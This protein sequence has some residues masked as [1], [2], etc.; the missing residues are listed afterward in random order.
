VR[1]RNTLLAFLVLAG[2]GAWIY[3][4]EYRGEEARKKAEEGEKKVFVFEQDKVEALELVKPDGT[5]SLKKEG[6]EWRLAAPLSARADGDEVSGLLSTLSWLQVT[7]KVATGASDLDA[8]KL[9]EPALRIVLSPGEGK[10]PVS[11]SVGDKAPIGFAYYARRDDSA[12]V[13]AVSSS[14]DRLLEA[15]AEKLRYKKV[16]G[17]DSWKV[18]RFAVARAGAMVAFAKTGEEWKMESPIAFPAERSKVSNLLYDLTA[19]T[20]EGFEPDGTAPGAVGLDPPEATL[21][22][23]EKEGRSVTVEFSAKDPN[24]IARARRTDMP[25]IFLVKGDV[26][27]K[28]ALKIEEFRDARVAPVDRW[29]ISEIRAVTAEGEKKVVKDT[30]ANWRWGSE[31]GPTLDR[32]KVDDLLDALDA[33]KGT[34]FREGPAA[35]AGPGE[36]R[37]TLAVKAGEAGEV[38]VKVGSEEGGRVL[39]GSTAAPVV[40]EVEKALAD[41][42]IEKAAALSAPAQAAS[43]TE[44]AEEKEGG[45]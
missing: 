13:V 45:S 39:I 1:L 43:G 16:L 42:L 15:T 38:E 18:G 9:K 14:V 37:V 27:E 11:L 28:L 31:D 23:E 10:P 34:A 26:L 3:F 7:Q 17:L 25:E 12:D 2:L 22:V 36:L 20:A 4:Y 29:T 40:Y 33:A 41:K 6:G 19:L 8:F 35:A 21:R 44:P 30:E 24:G 5:I 32:Q